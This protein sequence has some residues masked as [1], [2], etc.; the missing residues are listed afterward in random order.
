MKHILKIF[1]VKEPVLS[2]TDK[3]VLWERIEKIISGKQQEKVFL[4]SWTGIAATFAVLLS[5]AGG[6][7]WFFRS[8]TVSPVDYISMLNETQTLQ[9]NSISL[10]LPDNEIVAIQD[11]H[12][13]VVYD[14]DGQININSQPIKKDYN[15][16]EG[17]ILNT[18]VV[19]YG[20]TLSLTLN[21][22]TKVWVNS[23]STLI[24]PTVFEKNN[25]EIFLTG[26]VFLDVA[27]DKTRPFTIKTNRMDI[28]VLGTKF[29][30]SAYNDDPVQSVVLVSGAVSVKNKSRK[31]EDY[32]I[33]PGQMF[34]C[35]LT[36]NNVNIQEV[37][38]NYYTSWIHQYLLLQSESLDRVLRKLEKHFNVP[39]QYQATDFASIYVSGKLDL[40]GSIENA[41]DYI[42][43]TTP[44][45]YQKNNNDGFN[46]TLSTYK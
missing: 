11:E 46:I 30:V 41:L 7:Y 4:R 9:S 20:K 13:D 5:L 2:D 18:L 38:V 27:K 45:R 44:I 16:S 14:S 22:G 36:S 34:S 32:V 15:K 40:N 19:P 26:E 37:D 3:Q 17:I 31:E 28:N 21:D 12:S 24:Y 29:N 8:Q 33:R 42:G 39:I 25:R 10:I 35:D 23:G 43:I 6:A 1:Q